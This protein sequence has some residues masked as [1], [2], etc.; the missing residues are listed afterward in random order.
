MIM[1][2]GDIINEK[3]N[4]WMKY[5]KIN[6]FSDPGLFSLQLVLTLDVH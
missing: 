1:V 6:E 2:Y 5:S 4:I 3:I